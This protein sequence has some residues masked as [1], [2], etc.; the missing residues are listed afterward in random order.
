MESLPEKQDVE[1]RSLARAMRFAFAALVL[2]VSFFNIH[3]AL[4]ISNFQAISVDL[5]NGTPL[6]AATLWVLENQR[7]LQGLSMAIPLAAVALIFWGRLPVALYWLG[8]LVLL[9]LVQLAFAWT[10]LTAP[11]MEIIKKMQ[12]GP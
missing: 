7:I 4:S 1:I 8:S 5:L 12:G 3:R 10:A 9:A 2:G 6:P 11:L